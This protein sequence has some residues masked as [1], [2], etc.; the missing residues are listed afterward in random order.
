MLGGIILLYSHKQGHSRR[1]VILLKW[2]IFKSKIKESK[3]KSVGPT[4]TK[5][6]NQEKQANGCFVHTISNIFTL[7]LEILH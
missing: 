7:A 6:S 1:N 5:W 4:L 3:V 2:Y